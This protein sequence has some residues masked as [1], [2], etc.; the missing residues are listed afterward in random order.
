MPAESPHSDVS[1]LSNGHVENMRPRTVNRPVQ[2]PLE[3]TYYLEL[4]TTSQVEKTGHRALITWV[5]MGGWGASL[6][7]L[8]AIR[9]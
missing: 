6:A 5:Y 4:M 1:M 2:F 8:T 7:H 9:V 3:H